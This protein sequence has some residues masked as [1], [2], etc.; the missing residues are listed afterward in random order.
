MRWLGTA[1][2]AVRAF[3]ADVRQDVG[4]QLYLLQL[5]EEPTDW[6]PMPS[7]GPGACEIR[8]HLRGEYRVLY[9]AT[10]PEAVY[11]LHAFVKKTRRTRMADLELGRARLRD[12]RQRGWKR[13]CLP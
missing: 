2:T 3:P 8:V 10:R 5:G 7:V 6:R 9:V 12:L 4:Y 13:T 1:R 11:A